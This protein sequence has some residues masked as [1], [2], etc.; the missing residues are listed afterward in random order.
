VSPENACIY[1]ELVV[2]YTTLSEHEVCTVDFSSTEGAALETH[3]WS[4]R[5]NR[6]EHAQDGARGMQLINVT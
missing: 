4:P 5:Q 2:E 3:R 6:G 1:N